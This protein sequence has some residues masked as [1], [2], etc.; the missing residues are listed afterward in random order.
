MNERLSQFFVM[1]GERTLAGPYK[2]RATARS[3]INRIHEY[4]ARRAR[5]GLEP[6][7]WHAN[8]ADYTVVEAQYT[9][10]QKVTHEAKK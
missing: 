9:L 5:N 3:F 7:T 1:H 4:H 6:V 10:T 2:V 8:V